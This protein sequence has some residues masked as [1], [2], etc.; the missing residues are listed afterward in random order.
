ML[1]LVC[2]L[3]T[4]YL[5]Q[6]WTIVIIFIEYEMCLQLSSCRVQVCLSMGYFVRSM[7]QATVVVILKNKKVV[8]KKEFHK[9][10]CLQQK[11]YF[12][13]SLLLLC[14][15]YKCLINCTE[16][17]QH[18]TSYCEQL[19]HNTEQLDW[20]FCRI[21]G[22]GIV[23]IRMIFLVIFL[24]L[25]LKSIYPFIILLMKKQQTEKGHT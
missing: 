11:C 24:S 12:S 8:I 16:N 18:T 5:L 17:S 19:S 3:Q 6:S 10:S 13:S 20:C 9:S 25:I 15:E 4:Q 14:N 23:L 2:L 1:H 7:L 21:L 22:H